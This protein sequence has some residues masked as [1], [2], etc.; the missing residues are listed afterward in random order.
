[1]DAV[2]TKVDMYR[3]LQAGEFGNTTPMWTDAIEWWADNSTM[4]YGRLADNAPLVWG[5]RTMTPGGPCRLNCPW[6]EVSKTFDE[7]EAA[8]HRAQ[9]SAMVDTFATV[10]LWADIWDSP[11]G[12]VVYGIEYPDTK[13][14]TWR[15]GMPARGRHWH[16]TAAK[17][18]LDRHLNANSRD[19]LRILLEALPGHVVEMSALDRCYG[20]VSHRN[21]IV[22][23][24]RDGTYGY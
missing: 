1:M 15:S 17:L 24:V 10:T 19:D 8:G 5:V 4:G 20:T 18:L 23:E 14:Y 3:R 7:F 12:L 16:G 22:W 13:A 11:A 21:G 9:I 2:R 6:D